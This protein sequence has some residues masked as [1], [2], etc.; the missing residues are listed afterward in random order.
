MYKLTYYNKI[1]AIDNENYIAKGIK[2]MKKIVTIM[3]LI[4]IYIT[5]MQ[6]NIVN[7]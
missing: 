5:I 3:K 1:W 2:T 4:G 6:L 7:I